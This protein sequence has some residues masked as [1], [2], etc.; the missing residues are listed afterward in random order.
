MV[1]ACDNPAFL[2]STQTTGRIWNKVIVGLCIII[3][4][5][6]GNWFL[7]ALLICSLYPVED[8][9]E[10]LHC[11]PQKS[12]VSVSLNAASLEL[13]EFQVIAQ[14]HVSKVEWKQSETWAVSGFLPPAVQMLQSI[15]YVL[16]AAVHNFGKIHTRNHRTLLFCSDRKWYVDNH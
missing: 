15:Q 7:C 10:H 3:T 4:I 8:W 2:G 9:G 12:E 6:F 16:M 1:R 13:W 5:M 11:C 14:G